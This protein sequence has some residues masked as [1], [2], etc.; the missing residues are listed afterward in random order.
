MGL[1]V[2][3]LQMSQTTPGQQKGIRPYVILLSIFC[4]IGMVAGA[5]DK[6]YDLVLVCALPIGAFWILYKT[7]DEKWWRGTSTSAPS[8]EKSGASSA[9]EALADIEDNRSR[10]SIL[11]KERIRIARIL[12]VLAALMGCV[13]AVNVSRQKQT[14]DWPSVE[15]KVLDSTYKKYSSRKGEGVGELTASYEYIVADQIFKSDQLFFGK[16]K[17]KREISVSSKWAELV[18]PGRMVKVYYDPENPSRSVIFNGV[19]W[20]GHVMYGA[21]TSTFFF[22]GMLLRSLAKGERGK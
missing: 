18:S 16:K 4:L 13:V 6:E 1:I 10:K 14:S 15:G 3:R 12:F 9:G 22:T 7:V 21:L 2:N 11:R 5:R 19:Y 17:L 20:F 8:S